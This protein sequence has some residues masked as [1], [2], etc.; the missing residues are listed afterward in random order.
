[1]HSTAQSVCLMGQGPIECDYMVIGEAPGYREDQINKPFQGKAG[2]LLD[3]FLTE[4]GIPRERI[5]ITNAVKC[6]PPDNRTPSKGES[7][8]CRPWLEKEIEEVNPKYVMLLGATA[9]QAVLKKGKITQ[10]RGSVIELD[11]RKYMPVFHPAAGLHDPGKM[12]AVKQDIMRF[13]Q[14]IR[15]ELVEKEEIVWHILRKSNYVEFIQ[16]FTEAEEF[17]F[18]LETTRL[19]PHFLD[20]R[21]NTMSVSFPNGIT[22][23]IPLGLEGS[24]LYDEP[25]I[26]RQL[27]EAMVAEQRASKKK[28]TACNGLFDCKW[29]LVEFGVTFYLDDDVQLMDYILDENKPH[30]L[31]FMAKVDLN[32]PDYNVDDEFK[33]GI[34][35]KN[36]NN[37]NKFYLYNCLDSYYTQQLKQVKRAKLLKDPELRRLYYKLMMPTSRMF[38]EIEAFGGFTLD[39][40]YREQVGQELAERE[41]ELLRQ[42]NEAAGRE[43]NW[44]SPAQVATVLFQDWG[45][46]VLDM[47]DGGKP[48][49]GESVLL[50]LQNQH[51]GVKLLLE[52]RG[53]TKLKGTYHDGLNELMVGNILYL[54]TNLHGTVTGRYSSRLHQTPRD[55][56]IRSQFIA[57]EGWE[58]FCADYGQIELRLAAMISGDQRMKLV[59]STG[60]DIHRASAS[61]ILGKPVEDLTDEE[62]KRAKAVNFG[63]IYGMGE[64]KLMD[65]AR[66]KYEVILTRSESHRWR[67]RFF[68]MYAGLLPWHERQRRIVKEFGYVTNLAG[69]RR[70]L[71]GVYSDEDGVRSEAERQAINSPIQGFAGDLKAM[72]MVEIHQELPRSEVK[73]LGEV[74]DSILGIVRKDC[75]HHFKAIRSIMQKPK[76]LDDFGIRLTVPI[77]VDINIGRWG[78]KTTI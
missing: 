29:L 44:N 56:R 59:F 14:L 71:P 3:E 2:K 41:V 51:A 13:G 68:E 58:F 32:A 46:G 62:R 78:S 26:R 73:L 30:D 9:L 12:P 77:V 45:L 34:F 38:Q 19:D 49:T 55:K 64:V 16:Q 28:C 36:E 50:R 5:Y 27:I 18:D 22:W 1:M 20:S 76:L 31:K 47:T 21:I 40:E 6:R 8:A 67:K 66:D 42:L 72:G 4:A 10:L 52:Q 65:Y 15:G 7:K 25:D 39:M 37:L 48:S 75:F 53:V 61:D 74:H 69:R 70:R 33:K 63:L 35:E 17:S 23:L 54:S 60:G 11:G 57:P 43:I 24:F